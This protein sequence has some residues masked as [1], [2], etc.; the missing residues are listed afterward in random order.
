MK[1]FRLILTVL[2]ILTGIYRFAL[3]FTGSIEAAGIDSDSLMQKINA[4]RANR[5]IPKLVI[6]SKLSAAASAKT[7]DMFARGYFDHVDPD[8]HYVW[9]LVEAA[10]YKPYRMLGENLAIDFS[11]EDGIIRAWI[12]SPTHRDNMFRG[13]FSDQGLTGRYGTFQSRYTNIV[14]SLFGTLVSAAPK[15]PASPPAIAP[16]PALKPVPAPAPSPTVN[17]PAKSA[18]GEERPMMGGNEPAVALAPS[19]NGPE[20]KQNTLRTLDVVTPKNLTREDV[21]IYETVRTVFLALVVLL[22]GSV[23]ADGLTRGSFPGPWKGRGLPVLFLLVI[24]AF[25]TFNFY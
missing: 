1:T 22:L 12:D 14:T 15:T 24:A 23:L 7:D 17:E 10:G 25:L 9:P 4:E 13:E 21:N 20:Q 2:I 19:V 11:T 6:S 5:N 8:G 16:A 3:N 18:P